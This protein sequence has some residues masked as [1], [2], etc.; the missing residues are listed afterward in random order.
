MPDR[1]EVGPAFTM[2][3]P[4]NLSTTSGIADPVQS[5][6]FTQPK[7]VTHPAEKLEIPTKYQRPDTKVVAEFKS[8]HGRGVIKAAAAESLAADVLIALGVH[9]S[10]DGKS[11]VTTLQGMIGAYPDGRFGPETWKKAIAMLSPSAQ[12]GD[13]AS[14]QALAELHKPTKRAGKP[15]RVADP[16][17]E[18]VADPVAGKD[19][20]VAEPTMAEIEAK[21]SDMSSSAIDKQLDD[22]SYGDEDD[23]A[24]NAITTPSTVAYLKPSTVAKCIRE[25]I[26]GYCSDADEKAIVVAFRAVAGRGAGQLGEML[27]HLDSMGY[28]NEVEDELSSAQMQEILALCQRPGSGVSEAQYKKLKD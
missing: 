26:K 23:F 13:A 19:T 28:L 6:V 16:V 11:A 14:N 18:P 24:R 10:S 7:Q 5:G 8:L 27:S 3:F 22:A 12:L 15:T 4:A 17:A 25:M 20:P 2:A 21:M 1:T 9:A